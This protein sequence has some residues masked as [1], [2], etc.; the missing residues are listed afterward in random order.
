MPHYVLFIIKDL[1]LHFDNLF[2]HFFSLRL[3]CFI[4]VHN[5]IELLQA[6]EGILGEF[7]DCKADKN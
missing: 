1:T 2:I 7:S 4:L 5:I 6:S 3:S